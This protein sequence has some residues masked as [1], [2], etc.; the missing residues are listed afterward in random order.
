MRR[1]LIVPALVLAMC[2]A[3]PRESGPPTAQ[4]VVS[5]ARGI[6]VA[7]LDPALPPQKLEKW[8]SAPKLHLERIKW[9][10]SDCDLEPTGSH[11]TDYIV[12]ARVDFRRGANFG[13]ITVKVG[14][15]KEGIH[16]R[17]EIL[18]CVVKTAG[19]PPAGVF[20]STKR[21]SDFPNILEAASQ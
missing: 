3:G 2:D 10:S 19:V 17:P 21:L 6:D 20:R 4:A 5:Y 18:T 8:I 15:A 9:S 14:S 12:C 1:T 16:G 13:W 7:A 11:E